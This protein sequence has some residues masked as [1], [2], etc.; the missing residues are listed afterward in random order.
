MQVESRVQV[1][2]EEKCGKTGIASEFLEEKN[3]RNT[4]VVLISLGEVPTSEWQC[5]VRILRWQSNAVEKDEA[6]PRDGHYPC[7]SVL[8]PLSPSKSD[9]HSEARHTRD[10]CFVPFAFYKVPPAIPWGGGFQ[11]NTSSAPPSPVSEMGGVFSRMVLPWSS[12]RQPRAIATAYI[13]LGVLDFFDQQLKERFAIPRAL[14]FCLFVCL[15]FLWE[16]LSSQ[17]SFTYI[18]TCFFTHI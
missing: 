6:C 14:G 16:T 13:V 10:G 15:Y 9:V 5:R 3:G 8:C 12:G 4:N 11:V 2:Q 17:N 1:T 18:Y 7:W